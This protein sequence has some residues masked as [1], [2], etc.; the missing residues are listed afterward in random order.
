MIC[1]LQTDAFERCRPLLKPDSHV[2]AKA[3]VEGINSGRIFVNNS[4]L[5]KAGMVWLGNNDGFYFIGNDS[6][7]DFNNEIVKYVEEVIKPEMADKE[8]FYFEMMGNHSGWNPTIQKLFSHQSLTSWTQHVFILKQ[9]DYIPKKASLLPPYRIKKITKEFYEEERNI[10][11]ISYLDRKI[12]E[13]WFS[14]EDFFNKGLGYCIVFD[15]EIVGICHT[16]FAADKRQCIAIEISE[17]HQNKGLAKTIGHYYVQDCLRRGFLPYWDCKD[18][19]KSSQAVADHLG[20]T[21]QF[22]YRSYAFSY[23]TEDTLN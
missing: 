16:N 7:A 2:E 6:H 23:E 14:K 8:L 5:P 11:N 19:N 3:V 4:L 13:S 9:D 10:I 22:S 15:D 18:T 17:A 20:F 12:Q 1:E 21:H